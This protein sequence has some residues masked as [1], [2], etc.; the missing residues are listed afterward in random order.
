M[1]RWIHVLLPVCFIAVVIAVAPAAMAES[2]TPPI[3]A[4]IFIPP[5]AMPD[6]TQLTYARVITGSVPV[7]AAPTDSE[8]ARTIEQ[9]YVWVTLENYPVTLHKNELWYAINPNEWVQASYLQV[10]QPSSFMGLALSEPKTFAWVVFDT[11]TAPAPG[12]QPDSNSILLKRYMTLTFDGIEAVDGR[13][14]YKVG[15]DH[16]VEQGMLAVIWPKPRPEGVAPQDKWIEVDLYEQTLAAYEG[17]RMVYATLISSGLPWWQTEQGLFKI[18]AK[19]ARNKMSGRDG[20]PDYYFLED[21]PWSMYFNGNFALHGAYWHDKFGI[22]HS[23][24]CV[25][26]SMADSRWLFD[27]S[28]PVNQTGWKLASEEEPGTW[29]WVHDK[30]SDSPAAIGSTALRSTAASTS[31]KIGLR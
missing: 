21:V 31:F 24:G 5:A 27:W 14:W 29:V 2:P 9:G 18:W 11:Y 7:F 20:Y 16:W 13:D 25:N 10:Y 30:L 22:Q 28:T 12:Q 8:P 26:M 15:P 6:A 3:S 4:G 1:R 17:D 19:I 23:H